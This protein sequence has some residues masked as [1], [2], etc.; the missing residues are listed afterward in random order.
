MVEA[1]N[2]ES[3]RNKA[4]MIKGCPGS[5][6][7]TVT[8]YRLIRLLN[9]KRRVILLIYNEMLRI[10][11]KNTAI[12]NGDDISDAVKGL[13]KWF[14]AETGHYYA[15]FENHSS[16]SANELKSIMEQKDFKNR[17]YY[18]LL[19]DEGQD[20]NQKFYKSFPHFFS[21]ISVGADEAQKLYEHGGS[22]AIIQD[23]LEEYDKFDENVKTFPLEYNYRNTYST[24]N[25]ARQFVPNNA[26][27]NMSKMLNDTFSRNKG[28]KPDVRILK[29][30]TNHEL[31]IKRLIE[32]LTGEGVNI[33]V[34]L[35]TGG[36]VDNYYNLIKEKFNNECSKYYNR[37]HNTDKR[38]VAGNL[39]NI[40]ITTFHS[41]KGMEF[42][43]VILPEFNAAELGKNNHY[44]VASTRAANQLYIL[45][46]DKIPRIMES[47][48]RNTYELIDETDNNDNFDLP[49]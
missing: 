24:I 42:D 37:M 10:A 19:V 13:Y 32:N 23:I 4:I 3:P 38:I 46:I 47:F 26:M 7:T 21:R 22:E 31:E 35:S 15:R 36:E 14:Y 1:I 9:S 20:L 18:E 49:F 48:E 34:L 27:A 2:R 43:Y 29:S 8:I 39:K 45:C 5:G 17:V 44:Y 33:A 12:S 11:I 16:P 28:E 30:R 41:A 25:F 40:L 6:K